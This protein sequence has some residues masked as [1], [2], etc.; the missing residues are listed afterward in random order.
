MFI[1]LNL[2]GKEFFFFFW[3]SQFLEQTKFTSNGRGGEREKKKKTDV[4]D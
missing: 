4:L 3:F 2:I 1:F